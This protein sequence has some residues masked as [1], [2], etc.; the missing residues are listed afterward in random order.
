MPKEQK[1]TSPVLWRIK[2]DDAWA[3]LQARTTSIA[4]GPDDRQGLLLVQKSGEVAEVTKPEWKGETLAVPI[5]SLEEYSPSP[6]TYIVKMEFPMKMLPVSVERR[7][8]LA[9]TEIIRRAM[10]NKFE[11]VE[12]KEE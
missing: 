1:G 8:N 6:K 3:T 5:N 2:D 4:L 9:R 10:A 7:N 12:K 11:C